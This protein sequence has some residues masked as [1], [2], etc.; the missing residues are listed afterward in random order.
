M[1][2]KVDAPV[3]LCIISSA[4]RCLRRS[5]ASI[6]SGVLYC[7][8]LSS[9][10]HQNDKCFSFKSGNAFSLLRVFTIAFV[11]IRVSPGKVLDLGD[12]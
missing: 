2:G 3:W 4:S 8:E 5:E 9:L 11:V 10:E 6:V 7:L 12:S 1:K